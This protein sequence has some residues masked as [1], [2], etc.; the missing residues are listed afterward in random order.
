MELHKKFSLFH[1]IF[2]KFLSFVSCHYANNGH[3]VS[4]QFV[5]KLLGC[6]IFIFFKSDNLKVYNSKLF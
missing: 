6:K 2:K 5:D 3:Y 1:E 4:F